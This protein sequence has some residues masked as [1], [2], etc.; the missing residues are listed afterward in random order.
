MGFFL[1]V[2]SE[3]V[4]V[5]ARGKLEAVSCLNGELAGFGKC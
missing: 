3:N 2:S 4:R 1:T 5:L